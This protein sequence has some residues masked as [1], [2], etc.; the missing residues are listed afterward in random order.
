MC[1]EKDCNVKVGFRLM[2][3]YRDGSEYWVIEYKCGH[4]DH[5]LIES[6]EDESYQDYR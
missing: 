3:I 2:D 1:N 4:V 5:I 6:N